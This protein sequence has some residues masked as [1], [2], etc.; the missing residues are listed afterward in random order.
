VAT[1]DKDFKVKNGLV[2][3]LGGSFGGTV[4]VGTPTESN[5][6]ATK[7]Y[8]DAISSGSFALVTESEDPANPVDGQM[9]FNTT[10]RHISIYS[11]DAGAW[12]MIAT[13]DDTASLRQH[14]HDTAIDGTGLIVT[15]FQDAGFY[16][17]IFSA[18]VD[19]EFYSTA[20]WDTVYDGGTPV[21]NF[22]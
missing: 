16:D 1:T 4:I 14:I 11:E 6:A 15:V 8:V 7:E 2:V 3:A 22:N 13:F 21:D 19:G 20:S 17:A 5:H 9:Y 12:I 10:T 18:Y